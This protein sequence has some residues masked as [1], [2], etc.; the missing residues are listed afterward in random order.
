MSRP[1]GES[2]FMVKAIDFKRL[3]IRMAKSDTGCC[4]AWRVSVT[5]D[6][7]GDDGLGTGKQEKTT[8]SDFI[9]DL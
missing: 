4:S 5:F 8:R 1:S 2:Y 7:G 9:W 3:F 6:V